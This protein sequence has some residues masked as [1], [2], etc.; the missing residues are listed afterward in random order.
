[1]SA[2]LLYQCMDRFLQMCSGLENNHQNVSAGRSVLLLGRGRASDNDDPIYG[3][4][5]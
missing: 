5:Y 1:M 2:M 4:I 3:I